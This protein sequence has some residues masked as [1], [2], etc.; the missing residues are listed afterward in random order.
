MKKRID[1]EKLL[2]WAIRDE[3]P[4]GR[5]VSADIGF[6][7]GRRLRQRAFSIAR[8]LNHRPEVDSLGFVPGEPHEDAERVSD[9]IARLPTSV[10]IASEHD[11]RH[12]FGDL[13]G[14]AEVSI[15]S[16]MVSL[17]NQQALVISHASMG[18]RPKW[19]FA[20]PLPYQ[21]FAPTLGAGRPRAIVYGL[22]A[23]CDLVE[24]KRNE[25][26]ARKRD[27]EYTLAMSPRSPLDWQHP[28]PLHIGECRAEYVAW[29]AALVSLTVA[30]AGQ[31]V[32]FEPVAPSAAPMPWIT[33]ETPTSRI[34]E[35]A[36]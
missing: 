15:P 19:K 13:A 8:N 25:G 31:L 2:H 10:P 32:E 12:L 14:I 28:A 29:H 7:I 23:D 3:L 1:I 24:L 18:T 26:R 4:K 6:A 27:G 11:A 21:M 20:Y 35:R 5:P 34:L 17:F 9:S 36:A 30:L 22:D 33:G 16:L